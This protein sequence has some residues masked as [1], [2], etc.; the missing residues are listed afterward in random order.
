MDNSIFGS[1]KFVGEFRWDKKK[2]DEHSRKTTE[3][4]WCELLI[5]KYL[6]KEFDDEYEVVVAPDCN[7]FIMGDDGKTIDKVICMR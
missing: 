1:F 5:I 7:L 6:V 4:K 2:I 3:E